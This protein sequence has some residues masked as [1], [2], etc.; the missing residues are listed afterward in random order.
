MDATPWVSSTLAPLLQPGEQIITLGYGTI[1]DWDIDG[2]FMFDNMRDIDGKPLHSRQPAFVVFTTH[3]VLFAPGRLVDG[4]TP[5]A[6][7]W[8]SGV[9]EIPWH[10]I[11]EVIE[12][13]KDFGQRFL[14]FGV[15]MPEKPTHMGVAKMTFAAKEKGFSSQEDFVARMGQVAR[16]RNGAAKTSGLARPPIFYRLLT[17][18]FTLSNLDKLP[19]WA[20]TPAPPPRNPAVPAPRDVGGIPIDPRAPDPYANKHSATSSWIGAAVLGVIAV[21]CI[22]QGTAHD[23]A[24]VAVVIGFAALGLASWLVRR[25]RRL[26]MA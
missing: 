11:V 16:E 3:R 15:P 1:P 2:L 22:Q 24:R 25:A 6:L 21:F 19:A 18:Q 9:I 4:G 23:D 14:T 7:A 10:A 26:A 13:G 17:V 8:I 12:P 5:K 20:R